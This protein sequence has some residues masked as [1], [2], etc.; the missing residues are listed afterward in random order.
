VIHFGSQT[1]VSLAAAQL[2]EMSFPPTHPFFAYSRKHL[3][4]AWIDGV[5]TPYC[6]H[7]RWTRD[8]LQCAVTRAL[9]RAA[10]A[11]T[12]QERRVASL[13]RL[14]LHSISAARPCPLSPSFSKGDRPTGC[15]RRPAARPPGGSVLAAARGLRGRAG[16]GGGPGGESIDG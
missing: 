6:R 5:L 13:S 12:A 2:R 14:R 15:R 8:A 10:A 9:R 11:A 1:T 3:P 4:A 7:R 16:L